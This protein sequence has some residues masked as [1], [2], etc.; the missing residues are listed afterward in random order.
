MH[1]LRHKFHCVDKCATAQG[2][3]M[4][5]MAQARAQRKGPTK[6]LKRVGRE[7][8]TALVLAGAS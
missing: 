5:T 1:A 2:K 8:T 4:C 3:D 6:L 7:C